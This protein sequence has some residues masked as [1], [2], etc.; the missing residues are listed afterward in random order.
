M[1]SPPSPGLAPLPAAAQDQAG[2]K[3]N[4]VIVYGED[5]CPQ[6]TGGDIVVCA[7]MDESERY[8]IPE[9]LRFSDDPAELGPGPTA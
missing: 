9:A 1:P 3:V 2:D 6:S 7:R 8:R 5:E 4:T